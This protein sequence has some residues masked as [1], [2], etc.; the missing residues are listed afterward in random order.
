MC[1]Q[2][3][4]QLPPLPKPWQPPVPRQPC[5]AH[6]PLCLGVPLWR[7]APQHHRL[8]SANH[9][10][11]AA[12]PTPGLCVCARV[13]VCVRVC[14][15]LMFVCPQHHRLQSAHHPGRAAHPTPGLCVCVRVCV[16]VCVCVSDVCMPSAIQ[17]T[18]FSPPWACCPPHARCDCEFV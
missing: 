4:D 11:R 9:P 13:C 18:I 1:V 16:C 5:N 7:P 2:C 6:L 3:N 8:Q 10:G 14:A 15:C 12:Q 17:A